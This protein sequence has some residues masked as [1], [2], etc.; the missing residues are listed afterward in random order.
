VAER[1]GEAWIGGVSWSLVVGEV[2]RGPHER[3]V[4]VDAD[5]VGGLG[6]VL[7]DVVELIGEAGE[8]SVSGKSG[9]VLG[10]GAASDGARWRGWKAGSWSWA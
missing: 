10:V 3:C 9:V 2:G 8:A 1:R 5:V 4:P 7:V 6:G